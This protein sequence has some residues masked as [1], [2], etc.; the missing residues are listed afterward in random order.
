MEGETSEPL[1]RWSTSYSHHDN[2]GK[3]RN[4]VMGPAFHIPECSKKSE[5]DKIWG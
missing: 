5:G 2:N 1:E 4:V 3:K